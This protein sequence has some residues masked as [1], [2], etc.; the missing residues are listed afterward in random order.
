MPVEQLVFLFAL[1]V[2]GD[3]RPGF[4]CV[5]QHELEQGFK[6]VLEQCLLHHTL[7]FHAARRLLCGKFFCNGAGG[8]CVFSA[9]HAVRDTDGLPAFFVNFA[10]QHQVCRNVHL[11]VVNVNAL[12]LCRAVHFQLPVVAV[13]NESAQALRHG[14]EASA[15]Q[16]LLVDLGA[17]LVQR[18]LLVL[19]GVNVAAAQEMAAPAHIFSQNHRINVRLVVGQLRRPHHSFLLHGKSAHHVRRLHLRHQPVFSHQRFCKSHIPHDYLP[20]F[21]SFVVLPRNGH[22]QSGLQIVCQS[23]FV[24]Q[25]LGKCLAAAVSAFDPVANGAAFAPLHPPHL[26]VF[27][28]LQQG[29]VHPPDSANSAFVVAEIACDHRHQLVAVAAA[30]LG[31]CLR[32][33]F[34]LCG[35]VLAVALLDL[36]LRHGIFHENVIH[37]RHLVDSRLR[38]HRARML[39]RY[40]QISHPSPSAGLVEPVH[41]QHVTA[42]RGADSLRLV[43][44]PLHGQ[45]V[46]NVPQHVFDQLCFLFVFLPHRRH[47]RLW[48]VAVHL[49][50]HD[51][52]AKVSHMGCLFLGFLAVLVQNQPFAIQSSLPVVHAVPFRRIFA[53]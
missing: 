10:P 52:H 18:V 47:L 2:V 14:G 1:L 53:F 15:A 30:V 48:N 27:Q 41:D 38:H 4:V 9:L 6:Q 24:L 28:I 34:A 7:R 35:N 39:Q 5:G 11:R 45:P 31:S 40:L 12:Q 20:E 8:R 44:D 29:V 51:L 25:F 43:V 36:P 37:L 22:A 46:Q 32:V 21:V 26:V 17:Q 33:F 19:N 3:H 49:R 23:L 13:G 42:L 50:L 16:N